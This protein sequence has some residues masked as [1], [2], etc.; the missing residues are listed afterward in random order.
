MVEFSESSQCSPVTELSEVRG[1]T[2]LSTA[3]I[4]ELE[5]CTCDSSEE[6][7]PK[8]LERHRERERVAIPS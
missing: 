1:Q 4:P 2:G 6:D 3:N 7:T 8:E 5:K